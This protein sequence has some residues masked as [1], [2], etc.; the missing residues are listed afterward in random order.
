MSRKTIYKM[1]IAVELLIG[2]PLKQH[3]EQHVML[4]FQMLA[5]G[6]DH[7]TEKGP[8]DQVIRREKTSPVMLYHHNNYI[9]YTRV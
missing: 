5:I 8:K 4:L 6:Y 1:P 9:H 3:P 7:F 2:A